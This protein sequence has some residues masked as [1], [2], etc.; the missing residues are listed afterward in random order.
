MVVVLK[1]S[2]YTGILPIDDHVSYLYE[3]PPVAGA[4]HILRICGAPNHASHSDSILNLVFVGPR[5]FD[6]IFSTYLEVASTT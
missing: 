5:N 3:Y 1:C 4:P 2:Q 6:T